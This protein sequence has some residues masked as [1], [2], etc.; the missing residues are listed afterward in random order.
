MP[1]IGGAI[2]FGDDQ[3]RFLA[4]VGLDVDAT[5]D[6]G[7]DT[8]RPGIQA[9]SVRGAYYEWQAAKRACRVVG[10]RCSQ[11]SKLRRKTRGVCGDE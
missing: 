1:L 6:F 3:E 11:A 9:E 5:D 2:P 10:E 7:H 4:R 8:F